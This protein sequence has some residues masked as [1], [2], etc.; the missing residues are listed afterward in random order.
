M[1]KAA[2]VP[3]RRPSRRGATAPASAARGLAG[4]VDE[5]ALLGDLRTLVQSARQRI[6]AAA[7]ATQT[8]LCWHVGRRLAQEHLQGGRAAYGKQILVTVSRELTADYGR[9]FS[10]AEL[11]RMI[12]FT[13]AFPD[14]A[15]VVTLSQQLSWSH[16]HALLPIKDPLARDHLDLLF[17]HR[18]LR[19]LRIPRHR[20]QRST[21]MAGSIPP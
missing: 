10:Y 19:R 13:Q 21:L 16:F 18:H 14:E 12:Q 15:I 5:A 20:G 7:Y 1:K 4:P 17:F 3:A 9:G 6:A 8:L 11:A 2:Q